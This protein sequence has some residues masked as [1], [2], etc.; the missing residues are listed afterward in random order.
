MSDSRFVV[1]GDREYVVEL[2]LDPRTKKMFCC[3]RQSDFPRSQLENNVPGTKLNPVENLLVSTLKQGILLLY[4][5]FLTICH[6]RT[7]RYV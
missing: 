5:A 1:L 6:K 7:I 4:R 3:A 2:Y